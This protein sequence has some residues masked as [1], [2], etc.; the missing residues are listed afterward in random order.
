MTFYLSDGKT[1]DVATRGA[2]RPLSSAQEALLLR[3]DIR[4]GHLPESRPDVRRNLR[5]KN[6]I[7]NDGLLTN[8]AVQVVE[9]LGQKRGTRPRTAQAS[10]RP[11]RRG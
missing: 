10:A 2:S 4:S 7:D 6:L 11:A 9:A 5:R 3:G 1:I 8:L